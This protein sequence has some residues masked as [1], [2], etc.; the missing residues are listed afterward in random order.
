MKAALRGNLVAGIQTCGEVFF[1]VADAYVA[2]GREDGVA[3]FL[4][5]YA[6]EVVKITVKHLLNLCTVDVFV[7][8]G[9]E[10]VTEGYDISTRTGVGGD[11]VGEAATVIE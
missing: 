2:E 11:G 4:F 6:V 7:I 8:V 1:G 9:R 5:K 3:R 10:I